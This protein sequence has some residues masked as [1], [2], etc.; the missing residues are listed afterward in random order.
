PARE[1]SFE[2]S[3]RELDL[4][5]LGLLQEKEVRETE[6]FAQEKSKLDQEIKKLS[7]ER[8]QLERDSRSIWAGLLKWSGI[9][10]PIGSVATAIIALGVSWASLNVTK[11]LSEE[12]GKLSEEQAK[13]SEEQ[14]KVSEEQ[15]NKLKA[16]QVLDQDK[17]FREALEKATESSDSTPIFRQV[18]LIRALD[19]FWNRRQAPALASTLLSILVYGSKVELQQACAEELTRAYSTSVDQND[20]LFINHLLFGSIA[21]AA[22]DDERLGMVQEALAKLS[23]QP[24]EADPRKTALLNIISNAATHLENTNVHDLSAEG[25]LMA[26]ANFSGSK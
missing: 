22:G 12:Q 23:N 24:Q 19:G 8:E 18:A 9:I 11:H 6:R 3:K 4:A 5:N 16:D 10:G 26:G 1:A 25:L 21:T 13:L 7:L 2:K 17:F 20:R 14:A 15:I